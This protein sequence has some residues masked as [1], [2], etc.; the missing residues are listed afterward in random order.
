MRFR[1]G[2]RAHYS[3]QVLSGTGLLEEFYDDPQATLAALHAILL[4]T[5]DDDWL[6]NRLFALAEL[7]FLYAEHH[8][9]CLVQDYQC[10]AFKGRLCPQEGVHAREQAQAYYLA[11]AV[12]A[13]AL[14]FPEDQQY[15]S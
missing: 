9:P 7:S 14:L 3:L 11:A 2:L 5:P 10:L 1:L 6:N 12:Y 13:Y 15:R 8:K 4:S